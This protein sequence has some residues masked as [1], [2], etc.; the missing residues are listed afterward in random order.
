MKNHLKFYW[1]L[2][3]DNPLTAVPN[4]LIGLAYLGV[5]KYDKALEYFKKDYE[6]KLKTFG[7]KFTTV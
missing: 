7:N 3:K 6:F 2:W 4:N 1:K 5:E